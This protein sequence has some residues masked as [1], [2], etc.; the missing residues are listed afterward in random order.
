MDHTRMQNFLEPCPGGLGL[1]FCGFDGLRIGFRGSGR[2]VTLFLVSRFELAI[3]V[4]FRN[5][6]SDL[7]AFGNRGLRGSTR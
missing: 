4:S 5:Q 2:V 1:R 3:L 7:L 6:F